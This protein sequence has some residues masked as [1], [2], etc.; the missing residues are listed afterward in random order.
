MKLHQT[1]TELRDELDAE[2]AGYPFNLPEEVLNKFKQYYTAMK[3]V[4]M[5]LNDDQGKAFIN[6]YA[7]NSIRGLIFHHMT[8][9]T[10]I[11]RDILLQMIEFCEDAIRLD[12]YIGK[13]LPDLMK[14]FR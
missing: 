8:K 5:S 3:I 10:W 14:Q 12:R 9:T 11:E 6:K 1:L 4:A 2:E 13:K 7:L